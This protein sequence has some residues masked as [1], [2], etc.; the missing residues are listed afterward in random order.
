L[1]RSS[2]H[3]LPLFPFFAERNVV[4]SSTPGCPCFHKTARRLTL[5]FWSGLLKG[6]PVFFFFFFS[7]RVPGPQTFPRIFPAAFPLIPPFGDR[8][9]SSPFLCLRARTL[10]PPG[11]LASL[12]KVAFPMDFKVL[13]FPFSPKRGCFCLCSLCA[14]RQRFP[15]PMLKF[16][17]SLLRMSMTVS[18][19]VC[20]PVAALTRFFFCFSLGSILSEISLLF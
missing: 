3:D 1:A 17:F 15:T 8:V 13:F 16:R 18:M 6:G 2:G 19:T 4:L 7:L 12:L 5:C 20:R 10:L 9:V 11:S 14:I